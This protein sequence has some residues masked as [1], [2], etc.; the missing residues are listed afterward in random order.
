MADDVFRR[1]LEELMLRDFGVANVGAV[2]L[3]GFED[4]LPD[5]PAEDPPPR[6][7]PRPTD[8][9][10]EIPSLDELIGDRT[11]APRPKSKPSSPMDG[12]PTLEEMTGARVPTGYVDS[13]LNALGRGWN[14][15]QQGIAVIGESTG[16]LTPAEAAR[17]L[18]QNQRDLEQYPTSADEDQA[19]KDW[20][21]AKGF[22]ESAGVALSNP[23]D[24]AA[25]TMISSLPHSIPSV[26]GGLAGAAGGTMAGGPVGGTAGLVGGMFA[27]GIA[28]EYAASLLDVM[29]EEGVDTNDELSIQKAF[30]DPLLMA[31]AKAEALRRGVAVSAFDAATALVGGKLVP[32]AVKRGISKP[33]TTLLAGGIE[34]AG[35]AAGEAAG[36]LAAKGEITD[37]GDIGLE[38]IAEGPGIVTDTGVAAATEA[39]NRGVQPSAPAPAPAPAPT[40]A[41]PTA[42]P[43]PTTAG[44]TQM[45][46]S[47]PGGPRDGQVVTVDPNQPQDQPTLIVTDDQGRQFRVGKRVLTESGAAPPM[48]APVGAGSQAAGG[49]PPTPQASPAPSSPSAITP[50]QRALLRNM[51]YPDD[52]IDVMDPEQARYEAEAALEDGVTATP[53]DIERAR[54]YQPPAAEPIIMGDEEDERGVPLDQRGDPVV[55]TTEDAPGVPSGDGNTGPG[56]RG[57]AGVGDVP[58][59]P[60]APVGGVPDA[61]GL[62]PQSGARPAQQDTAGRVPVGSPVVEPGRTGP[63]ESPED[64]VT[65]DDINDLDMDP[66]AMRRRL[67]KAGVDPDRAVLIATGAQTDEAGNDI[68]LDSAEERRLYEVI[69]DEIRERRAAARQAAVDAPMPP[70]TVPEGTGTRKRP[71]KVTT[72]DDLAP[73]REVVAEPTD[74]QAQAGNYQKGH[75]RI[76]GMDVSIETPKGGTRRSKD[77]ANPW[78]AVSP[79]DYGYFKNTTGKDG[80]HLDVF[81]GPKP[82][83]GQAFVIDQYD[84]ATGR[85]DEHKVVLGVDSAEEAQALYDAAFSDGS[86]PTRRGGIKAMSTDDLRGRL[87]VRK[88]L[89]RRPL[90]GPRPQAPA[91]APAPAA[92]PAAPTNP[93]QVEGAGRPNVWARGSEL[94]GRDLD[95]VLATLADEGYSDDE[96]ATRGVAGWLGED[97]PSPDPV[98]IPMPPIADMARAK[99][100]DG[101]S[102]ERVLRELRDD[103]YPEEQIVSEAIPAIEKVRRELADEAERNK[104]RADEKK[105]KAAEA[106]T[107]AESPQLTNR[108]KAEAGRVWDSLSPG[109]RLRQIADAGIYADDQSS[110]NASQSSWD[111]LAP[112]IRENVARELLIPKPP[113]PTPTQDPKDFA[114]DYVRDKGTMVGLGTAMID[115]GYEPDVV[116]DAAR[117]AQESM[118]APAKPDAA[119]DEETIPEGVWEEAR[120]ALVGALIERIDGE[121]MTI[122]EARKIAREV[123]PSLTNKQVEEL[124]EAAM[125]DIGRSTARG[126]QNRGRAPLDVFRSFVR[127]YSVQ[128]RLDQ[129]TS[130]SMEQ[131]AYSTPL[132]LAYL[133]ANL[134]EIGPKDTVYEPTAG[135]GML[136][137]TASPSNIIANELNPDRFASLERSLPS[138]NLHQGDAM[139]YAPSE[140]VDAVI[141]NPPFGKVKRDDQTSVRWNIDGRFTP[142]VDHAIAWRALKSMRKGGRAVLIIG[143]QRG[144][145][146]ERRNGYRND[147]VRA[148]FKKLYDA[149]NVVDH[150]TVD[151]KLYERQGASWPVDV[152]VI[153]GQGASKF[154]Y[155][156]AEPPP[157]YSSWDALEEKFDDRVAT[158][159]KPEERGSGADTGPAGA[160]DAGPV[161]SPVGRPDRPA[162]QE[163]G[164]QEGG[165]PASGG[166]AGGRGADAEP[167]ARGGRDADGGAQ[168]RPDRSGGVA[169]GAGAAAG[170]GARSGS[171]E[172]AGGGDAGGVSGRGLPVDP[173]VEAA[174]D[175]AMA[176]VFGEPAAEPDE[177]SEAAEALDEVA[178]ALSAAAK[179]IGGKKKKAS[180]APA[181]EPAPEPTV[182]EAAASAVSNAATGLDEV[183]SGLFQLF[184][185]PK[186]SSGFSFDEETWAKAK[187]LFLSGLSHMRAAGRDV[188]DMMKALLRYLQEKANFT[189]D[190]VRAMRPYITRVI[191]EV[192]A[193]VLAIPQA[194]VDPAS[195]KKATKEK[196]RRE[197]L[198]RETTYQVAYEPTSAARFAVG[199]LVPNNMQTA[200]KDS[201]AKLSERVGDIDEYVAGK[202][203]YTLDELLG[204]DSKPGYFSAEQVDA[205]A[206]A[207]SNVEDGGGFIIGD[208]TGVGKGRF[209]AAMI[210]YAMRAG[211]IPVFFTKQPGLY[212]DMVRDLRDIGM[213]GIEKRIFLTNKDLTGSKTIPLS[214]D[215]TDVLRS[216]TAAQMTRALAQM[217]NGGTLGP[218]F[219]V[220]FTTYAQVNFG[221]KGKPY[222]RHHA[223]RGIAP[224]AMFILDESHLAGGSDAKPQVDKATGNPIPRRQDFVRELLG[225]SQ[226]AV[227]SSA[228]YAKNPYVMSLYFKTALGQAM[229]NPE[230]LS[231]VIKAGGVPL[232]QVVANM[233]V[234]GGQYVRRERSFDGVEM[235]M[236]QLPTDVA[237]ADRAAET[238][239][240]VFGLDRDFMEGVRQ[241]YIEEMA[242]EGM[243]AMGDEAVGENSASS[244]GFA[245]VMH[246]VVAQMLL[247]LK[248]PAV[249]D[250]AI[251]LHKAGEKPIIALANT[252]ESI[253]NDFIEDQKLKEGDEAPITFNRI[254]DRYVNR[255]RRIGLKDENDKRTYYY[256]TDD[257][258]ER[259]GGE[260]ALEAF[261]EVERKVKEADLS[262]LPA[263]PID[264]VMDR[265]EQAGIQVDEITGRQNTLR[266]GV[267]TKRVSTDR[268][269]KLVM[270]AF[271][272]GRV[273]ALIINKSG[274]TGFSLHA[275]AAKNNDGKQ[276]HMLLLQPDPN[277][278]DFMQMLGRIHRTGQIKLPKYTLAISDL[279][280]EKRVAAV[281]MKKMAS[282]NANTTGGKK[283]AVSLEAV[284]FMNEYGDDVVTDFLRDNPDIAQRIAVYPP[285][286]EEKTSSDSSIAARFTGRLA[287]L[288]SAEVQR[289]YDEI[290]KTYVD[291]VKSLENMGINTLEARTIPLDAETKST[292]EMV[293]ARDGDGPFDAAAN[294]ETVS[295]ARLGSPYK[296]DEVRKQ[297]EDALAG[298]TPRQVIEEAISS[299]RDKMPGYLSQIDEAIARKEEERDSTESEARQGR[300]NVAIDHLQKKRAEAEAALESVIDMLR[301][302]APGNTGNLGVNIGEVSANLPAVILDIDTRR[303]R[304]NPT[305][306]SAIIIRVA[307]GDASRELRAP[308]SKFRPAVLAANSDVAEDLPTGY[309]FIPNGGNI[310]GSP[311]KVVATIGENETP[312]YVGD[313][314]RVDS[315]STGQF[316]GTITEAAPYGQVRVQN[317]REPVSSWQIAEVTK[318]GPREWGPADEAS[319]SF[320][321]N[322]VDQD[323]TQ[324]REE[325]QIITGNLLAGF[326]T[327]RRGQFIFYT[328]SAGEVRQGILM[329]RN[330]DAQRELDS[331]AFRFSSAETAAQFLFDGP[332]AMRMILSEDGLFSASMNDAGGFAMNVRVQGGRPWMLLRPARDAF[333]GDFEQRRGQPLAKLTV[334]SRERFVRGLKAYEEN[335]GAVFITNA[336]RAEARAVE[337][338]AASRG[339]NESA[340]IRGRASA[341]AAVPKPAVALSDEQREIVNM[342]SSIVGFAAPVGFES[343][344]RVRGFGAQ[345]WGVDETSADGSFNW[346]TNV[347]K[348]AMDGPDRRRAARHEIGHALQT[349]YTDQERAVLKAE[350]DRLREFVRSHPEGHPDI[351]TASPAEVEAEA[352]ALYWADRQAQ[353]PTGSGI[354]IVIRR[355]WERIIATFG[356]VRNALQGRGYQ[357]AEDVFKRA[358]AGGMRR[359]DRNP[360]S[361]A[362]RRY[363]FGTGEPEASPAA[364]QPGSGT[365]QVATTAG[366]YRKAAAIIAG[367][368][369]RRVLD[370][371]AGLGL[372]SDAMSERG[373]DVSSF[374]PNPQRWSGKTPVTFTD[375]DQITGQYDGVVSLNVL[376]VLEP[377][378][379][380]EVTAD[381]LARVAPGGSALIGARRWEGDVGATKNAEVTGEPDAIWVNKSGVRVYQKGFSGN[382]LV[383][384]VTRMAGEG[385]TVRRVNGI[386][387]VGVIA[388]RSADMVSAV[389][390]L[391][392]GQQINTPVAP[393]PQQT[394]AQAQAVLQRTRRHFSGLSRMDK[395]RVKVQDRFLAVRRD[396]ERMVASGFQMRAANDT[397][398]AE[399]RFPGKAGERIALLEERALQPFVRHLRESGISIEEL[400]DYLIARHAEERTDRIAQITNGQNMEGA[401]VDLQ[402]A[403][404][405]LADVAADARHQDFLRAAAMI[406]K[407]IRDT[408]DRQ[409]QSGLISREEY[410]SLRTMYQHYVPLRG[411][412]ADPELAEDQPL[413]TG[414]GFDIR[415]KENKA[416]FG[417]TTKS[418]SPTAYVFMAAQQSIIRSEKNRVL[419]TFL[420]YVDEVNDP[421]RFERVKGQYRKRINP[422]TGFVEVYFVPAQAMDDRDMV[423]IKQGGREIRVRVHDRDIL[424]AL[425]QFGS[426]EVNGFL[427][428]LMR[429]ARIYAQLQTQWNPSF[430]VPNFF[431]DVETALINISDVENL[432][433]GTRRRLTGKLGKSIWGIMKALRESR[434]TGRPPTG[435]VGQ[436]YEEFRLAGGK[437]SFGM[438]DPVERIK[439]R[440]D[441]ALDTSKWGGVKRA[442]RDNP[443]FRLIT[444]A[445]EAVENGVRLAAYIALREAAVPQTKAASIV[446]NLTTNFNRRGEYGPAI[447]A[448]YIFF[449]ASLQGTTRM[450]HS[451]RRSRTTQAIVVSLVGAGFAM[452]AFN[453]LVSELFGDDDEE[454]R[455][456][457]EIPDYVKERNFVLMIPGTKEYLKLP[458]AFGYSWFYNTGRLVSATMRGAVEPGE[459]AK[460]TVL[461]ALDAF[462]PMGTAP[463]IGQ[464]ITPTLADPAVQIGENLNFFGSPIRPENFDRSVPASQTAYDSVG[465]PWRVIAEGLNSI[466]GG[467]AG[468]PG[469][470]DVSPEDIEHIVEFATGGAGRFIANTIKAG[471]ALLGATDTEWLPEKTPIL[472]SFYGSGGTVQAQRD[473]FYRAWREVDQADHEV[474]ELKKRGDIEMMRQRQREYRTEIA[475][476]PHFSK[477]YKE[478]GEIR[479]EKS[480]IR[481]KL[482]GAERRTALE[483]LEEREKRLISGV[484]RRLEVEEAN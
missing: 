331:Q 53:D 341:R 376:N 332:R 64:D 54:V 422:R 318:E 67:E 97:D 46:I 357:T 476:Y 124:V 399:E 403:N 158:P 305:A 458:L 49:P 368:G 303:V 21:N 44:P 374:E 252:N 375:S 186:V 224:S 43:A 365:T 118:N 267:V 119:D 29:R 330:F 187:P 37:A 278:D 302:M 428:G 72:E 88:S 263:S 286:G 351:A 324:T 469:A 269:K 169:D 204:T 52:D 201:L 137:I 110:R 266:G 146:D 107:A 115:A 393:T 45:V 427:R 275:T 71:A 165:V 199:T 132:P 10:T 398:E 220:V 402:S 70:A 207:I 26:A 308:L 377:E 144:T 196:V 360:M 150:F 300:A 406:D 166:A 455:A 7:R 329:P 431:R 448:L 419:R 202:L 272:A 216:P 139:A 473:A 395:L 182:G 420:R 33:L 363:L 423:S 157:I 417:R 370:Y 193:G 372:G 80:D 147:D 90:G 322:N 414:R 51:G 32:A 108:Q 273:N 60:D 474:K 104:A 75:V 452:D 482:S 9:A 296:S 334:M 413:G 14:Q 222:D 234:E 117:A 294:V 311:P 19:W 361:A 366:S 451:I 433:P 440:I 241:A 349:L 262:G 225:A 130:T 246:N 301:T 373:L 99:I 87:A 355:A 295:V 394:L 162:G 247:A 421:T 405:V 128:P 16:L 276:R 210:R 260:A 424:R 34:M 191:T 94:Q 465:A 226:G 319:L 364:P 401:G 151:G 6:P 173:E 194:Q 254:L 471:G 142:L 93:A 446:R 348:I 437:V 238:L 378:L 138:A 17:D 105:A 350:I 188:V 215:P 121:G 68:M 126:A 84:P 69:V 397:Y 320:W 306:K 333:A 390:R 195:Q 261:K 359:R 5:I 171:R 141:T 454:K 91:P 92:P 245:N 280:V 127:L 113:R 109:E 229:P 307:I 8:P 259:L 444:D 293:P 12:I 41:A 335:L 460:Q 35:G 317:Y 299:L 218:E 274:S 214:E 20:E 290:E 292:M 380:D 430:I 154:S 120:D 232:Q 50:E 197:N 96:I 205:L 183:A 236:E 98:D 227:Y 243:S 346:T 22:W 434:K 284:D 156:M 356:R 198:E 219:D 352:F 459:A 65:V 175:E 312:V 135:N 184:G 42:P 25:Q 3:P 468:R 443:V 392:P 217:Q 389:R 73:A 143:G 484:M 461:S 228:T 388:T 316:E 161:S 36:Q 189:A 325:R 328:T 371:G 240:E 321:D 174:F 242:S 125:V 114:L 77:P 134:A 291:Y 179:R 282:L 309:F 27:G 391:R 13:A 265:L 248:A 288:P 281:L 39:I 462:N 203:G 235:N 185:G 112:G 81:I 382:E 415:G 11:T 149:Y 472:N 297:L 89:G 411:W 24:I 404:D 55:G 116:E 106:A 271:N 441:D 477:V 255:L 164:G 480:R 82:D 478:L 180:T 237:K 83:N 152:I 31:R 86:G 315:Y 172:G 379:R 78:E 62:D 100:Y 400:D 418:D 447:N 1:R 323:D 340:S 129:R 384:Y 353:R 277:I 396:Q 66:D 74:A 354:H 338:A 103:G 200:I 362:Q 178:K 439:D 289:I 313:R 432:P 85:F 231:E 304:A 408:R 211:K 483:R 426:V 343:E 212:G 314:I 386:G 287:I 369:G 279:A 336:N 40:T 122:V 155:P 475:A 310:A 466:T 464:Y 136:L 102:D 163:G 18:V 2:P 450:L 407:V 76:A 347:I 358:L 58:V 285:S 244:V 381:I 256:L 479:R 467:T 101:K 457:D 337:D 159:R 463:S 28:P 30:E 383:D 56:G 239:G 59:R 23:F 61:E 47:D 445:N 412:E 206:L 57:G 79:A 145:T 170:T 429:V 209:V 410:D 326:E 283:S 148:F 167:A 257:D 160:A 168:Q 264:Y 435:A 470:I 453:I 438:V 270:N 253:I 140:K 298:R 442:A 95:T 192:K 258:I 176:E 456:Y 233:L 339:Q 38:A 221:G 208:Q 327:F 111:E 425:Q 223:L 133:A 249:A 387:A 131:Q 123:D 367:M 15:A 153:D 63:E 481:D 230:R 416:A 345:Q 436:F 409:F 251:A 48:A 177:A 213:A 190:M 4:R 344:I 385:W 342:V 181:A 268:S 250:R 449:N